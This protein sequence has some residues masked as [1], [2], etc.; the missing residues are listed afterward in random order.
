MNKKAIGAIIILMSASLLGIAIIQWFWI[1]RAVDLNDENFEGR[2][3]TALSRVKDNLISDYQRMKNLDQIQLGVP[4]PFEDNTSTG[5]LQRTRK[6]EM[7]ETSLLIRTETYFDNLQKEKLDKYVKRELGE[8]G[9]DLVFDYGVYSKENKGFIILNGNYTVPSGEFDASEAESSVERSLYDSRYEIPLFNEIDESLKV[10]F[11][12]KN[13]LLW[14]DV[15]PQM[16]SSIIFT[17]LVLFCFIYTLLVI[18]KQKK[19]SEITNDFINN[20]THEFK[21][22]IATIS[23]AADSINSPVIIKNEDKV[24]RFIGIIKQENK[25]ML[26]QVE[27]V[28]Q[29]A[30]LEKEDF[31]M[32][33]T[34][35][36]INDVVVQAVQ[37]AELQVNKREGSIEV[38]LGASQDLIEAD[39]TH[40]SNIINNLLDNANKYS[41]DA[42]HIF[43]RTTN[44]ASGVEISIQ[45]SGLGMTKEA[46]KHIFDKFYRVHTGNRHDVKGF[47][48]GLSYVKAIVNAHKGNIR[49]DSELGK[50][51]TFII[52]LP[53]RQ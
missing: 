4:N 44:V 48:L 38:E 11:P 46:I 35:V 31:D 12:A 40:I 8:Q 29:M 19:I 47:G 25:R 49:V 30:L 39:M 42:P 28:L 27:K 43:V 2:V 34:G 5:F 15:L 26:S 6:R 17:S 20:M 10:Y 45:D 33:L 1:K 18:F 13:S 36:H 51:S 41:P 9:I 53:F 24:K 52:F 21:T 22:P 50:G 32:K 37:N 23:L 16:I 14:A 3:M 7:A